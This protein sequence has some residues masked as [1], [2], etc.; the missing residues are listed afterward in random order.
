MK[1]SHPSYDWL[2]AFISLAVGEEHQQQALKASVAW[3]E[4]TRLPIFV[5]LATM[6]VPDKSNVPGAS[7][8]PPMSSD[9][10]GVAHSPG[11]NS[12]PTPP[13]LR[14]LLNMVMGDMSE[15]PVRSR[16]FYLKTIAY[17]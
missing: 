4:K 11:L 1:P 8:P 2:A 5:Q 7:R 13:H 6:T 9:Y 10:P 17:Y 16:D 12:C 3:F 14:R 15:Y